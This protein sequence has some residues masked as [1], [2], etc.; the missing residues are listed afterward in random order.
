MQLYLVQHGEALPAEVDPK[1][2]LSVAGEADV[3]RIAAFLAGSGVRVARVLHSGKRRAEQTAEGLAATLAPGIAPESRAGL[4]PNDST[5]S[6]ALELAAW[7]E[8]TILVGHLPFMA[9]LASRLVAGREDASL[10][11]FEPGSVVCLLRT[12]QRAWTVAWMLRPG[13]LAHDR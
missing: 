9:R 8:D 10:V 12:D 3:R 1:R 13:L 7:Q 5:E 4:N 2:P 6:L 11:A